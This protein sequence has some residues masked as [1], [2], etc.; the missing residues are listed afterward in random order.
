MAIYAYDLSDHQAGMEIPAEDPFVILKATEG[1]SYRS[2]AMPAWRDTAHGQGKIVGLYHFL[3]GSGPAEFDNFMA[4]TG[5]LWENEFAICDWEASELPSLTLT[6]EPEHGYSM[7]DFARMY[8][9][10]NPESSPST[11][12]LREA[13]TA[14]GLDGRHCHD[15]CLRTEGA[16]GRRPLIYSYGP[17]LAARET[18]V[19]DRWPLHIAAYGANDGGEHGS[20]YT[21][22]WMPFEA[23]PGFPPHAFR[24]VLW[25]YTSNPLDRNKFLGTIEQL[26]GLCGGDEI[27]VEPVVAG[28]VHSIEETKQQLRDH[29]VTVGLKVQS[30]LDEHLDA[31]GKEV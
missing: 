19:L 17:Y 13:L 15:W 16:T 30:H 18:V 9:Q 28:I 11:G 20:P 21:D 12:T 14:T 6:Q 23:G 22:R 29:I 3:R 2:R 27:E 31:I 25:Q 10:P 7:G 1:D 8:R 5:G 26:R 4:H 24:T